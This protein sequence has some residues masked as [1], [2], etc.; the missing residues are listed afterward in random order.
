MALLQGHAHVQPLIGCIPRVLICRR[1]WL[2]RPRDG[3]RASV[4]LIRQ[5][6]AAPP[7][8]SNLL[9]LCPVVRALIAWDVVA[10]LSGYSMK[11]CRQDSLSLQT[12]SV[13]S[14]PNTNDRLPTWR[15]TS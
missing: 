13:R 8:P 3:P 5:L 11:A 9:P 15:D 4:P 2:G 10:V 6:H 12:K 1:H 14:I 7:T